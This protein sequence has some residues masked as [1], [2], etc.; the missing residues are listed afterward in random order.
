TNN[1]YQ[2]L[3][4]RNNTVSNWSVL[5]IED[6]PSSLDILA[7]I[8]EHNN[9]RVDS[10]SSGEAALE[11]LAENRYDLAIIDLA[12]PGIDGW[13]LQQEIQQMPD[14]KN[15]LCIALTAFYTPHLAKEAKDA[16]F[17]AAFPKP[18]TQSLVTSLQRL[19]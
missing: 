5:I 11:L 17:T 13:Q 14:A 3:Q 16:G 18:I 9:M 2:P 15:T 10:A 19:L 4:Q 6:D 1:F 8:L 7:Q 12:L